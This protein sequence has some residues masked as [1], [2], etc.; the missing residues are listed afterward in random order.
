MSYKDRNSFCVHVCDPVWIL[1]RLT[2]QHKLTINGNRTYLQ[3]ASGC[4]SN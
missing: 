3:N 4:T 1:S 2:A